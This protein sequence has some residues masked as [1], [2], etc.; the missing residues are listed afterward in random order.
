MEAHPAVPEADD[1]ERA[2]IFYGAMGQAGIRADRITYNSLIHACAKTH[3]LERAIALYEAMCAEQIAPE[4]WNL[5]RR[6]KAEEKSAETLT[7]APGRAPRVPLAPAKS[8]AAAHLSDGTGARKP[9]RR[10]PA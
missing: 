5:S 3:N 2:L 1:L 10:S 7:P 6:R 4:W 9:A 8:P